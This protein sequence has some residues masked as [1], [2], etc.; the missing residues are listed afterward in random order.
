MARP[1]FD[2]VSPAQMSEQ[3][4]K[5]GLIALLCDVVCM[6][7]GFF[8]VIPLISV[9]YVDGLGWAAGTIGL[10][11]A[12]RQLTQQGLTV[13]G[14]ALA[15]KVGAKL[16][17]CIGLLIRILSFVMLAFAGNFAL[18]LGA[19]LLAGVGGALFESPRAAAIASLTRPDERQRF[20]SLSGTLGGVGMA[21]GP[22]VGS[23]LLHVN[24]T[25]VCLVGAACFTLNL[26]QT[27]LM[28]PAVQI[29][30]GEQRITHGISMAVHDAPFLRFTALMMGYY[31]MWVQLNISLPL[32]AR[33][34]TG[35]NDSIGMLYAINSGMVILLQYPL[36]RILGRR[37]DQLLL[38][39]LGVLAMSVGIASV[40]LVDSMAGLVVSVMLFSLGALVVAPT[41]QTVTATLANPK[42]FG[43]YFGVSALALAFGGSLGNLLGGILY[44]TGKNAG[45]PELPWLTFGAV[46]VVAALGLGWLY[47]QR[48]I[49]APVPLEQPGVSQAGA[50]G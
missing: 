37:M 46:G 11:L 20:Y 17:I 36:V 30:S 42:A 33:A 22:L 23:Q 21:I 29:A 35:S 19:C 45:M 40:A 39:T 10:V 38:L 3:A 2:A 44:E 16:L 8:M 50:R 1:S 48:R 7:T 26:L 12:L 25:V 41:Q 49:T 13:F 18:L 4:R 14:G 28:L 9:Q 24:F 6:Y 43:S 15:D 31:F 27:L 5:R 32:A 34:I 47:L